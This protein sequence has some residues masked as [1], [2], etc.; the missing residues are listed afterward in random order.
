MI[1][2]LLISFKILATIFFYGLPL[3]VALYNEVINN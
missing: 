1:D 3:W 2:N